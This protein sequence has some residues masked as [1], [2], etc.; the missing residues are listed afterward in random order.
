MKNKKIY[1]LITQGDHIVT[2]EYKTRKGPEEQ[3]I[4]VYVEGS[5]EIIA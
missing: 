1:E 4:E 5:E 2:R 3:D